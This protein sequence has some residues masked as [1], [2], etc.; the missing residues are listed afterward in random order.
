M[1]LVNYPLFALNRGIISTLGL[2]RTDLK[3]QALSAETQTNWMPRLLGSM[4]LRPGLQYIDST[5]NN[6]VAK[7]IPFVFSN[8]DTAIVELTDRVM[9]VRVSDTIITRPSVSTAVS[10]GT[11]TTDLTGWTNADESGATSAWASG[12]FMR[13]TGDGTAYAIRR[14]QVTVATADKNTEHGIHIVI[15]RGPVTLRIGSSSGADDYVT[16]TQ[17]ETGTHSLSVTPT[18]DIFIEFK[19]NLLRYVQVQSCTIESAG[20]MEV[21][22]PWIGADLAK[23]RYDQSADVIFV[24]CSGY[25]QRR[26][27]RRATRSWSVVIYKAEDG[28]FRTQNLTTNT[29]T[30]SAIS[31]NITLTA[32]KP[33]FR[34]THV[35][36]IFQ[37]VSTGQTVTKAVS[38]ENTFSDTIKVTGVGADR[39]FT[40]NLTGTWVGTVTLQRSI[41]SSTGPFSDVSG[42]SWTANT[43]VTYSDGLDNQIVYY[44]IGVKTGNY[45]SGTVT[46]SLTI[47]TGSITGVARILTYS[48]STSVTAEVLTALGA[49]TATDNWSEGR[50]SDYRGWP[51]AVSLYEGRL[52]WFGQDQI[53]GSVTDAF[54]SF[55]SAT[56]GDSGP[57]S[58]S[59]GSG[60]VDTINWALPL[61]RLLVG[62]QGSEF[63]IRS[64]SL[65][66]PLTPTNFNI[67]TAATQGSASVAAIKID[68]NGIYIQK[69]GRRVYQLSYSPNF[70]NLDYTATDL[71]NF[72][73]DLSVVPGGYTLLAVQRQ[74]DTRIHA[75]M[76]DGTVAVCVFDPT[77]DEKAWI[78][79][80]TSGTVEDIIVLPSTVE[81]S[82]YYVVNR[83]INGSTKRYIEKWARE[84]ECQ[85]STLNKQADAFVTFAN[86]PASATVTGLSHLEG[87]SVVVWADSKCLRDANNNIATFT[88]S[89][90]QITLTNNGSA[91]SA[92]TGIVGLPYTAQFKSTKLAYG[93]QLGTALT[94]RKSIN[95]LGLILA[96]THHRGLQHGRDFSNL[97][98]M[99]GNESGTTVVEDTVWTQYDEQPSAFTKSWSTDERL[100][101]QAQAPRPVTVLG[102]VIGLETREAA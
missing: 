1:A 64:S 92:T 76:A 51:T 66:E 25:Q 55:D 61:Q 65:D 86:S 74:P 43:T 30:P 77:E 18:G 73:P 71:T 80:T 5:R 42:E 72:V 21:T 31:G 11:F 102:C 67:K 58:R 26:I 36:S 90:G 53:D 60:P 14:Q 52:W 10:N 40:I 15:E 97:R 96:N 44:R 28:P 89:S 82:V 22:A 83:T 95:H 34:S 46:A 68:Y 75:L 20:A 85:G 35:G 33:L 41:D 79:V 99:P 100:C 38:A 93:A 39:T 87:K 81:D 45:T 23:I 16:E 54:A 17:L 91:Y 9:R 62:G 29:I 27:E 56:V 88:V 47:A 70:F 50:W 98:D 101:L 37:L 63:S 13:L 84:D 2:A 78:L 8:T 94:Q 12:S 24:A 49:I 32:L 19:A 4:M 69:S 3:R 7:H 6:A 48:S 59:I 57:I